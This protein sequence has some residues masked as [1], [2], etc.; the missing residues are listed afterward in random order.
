LEFPLTILKL[1]QLLELDL[2]RNQL[3]VVPEKIHELSILNV[4]NLEQN[5]LTKIPLTIQK[6]KQ[7][8]Q[9]DLSSNRL[10]KVNNEWLISW[11]PNIKLDNNK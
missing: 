1:T 7:L 6:M 4:L 3:D 2:S 11:M 5:Q 10:D 9:L 8:H